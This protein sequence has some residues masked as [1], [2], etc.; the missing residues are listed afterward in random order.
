MGDYQ[1]QH[2][3]AVCSPFS[4]SEH[5]LMI[6]RAV[7]NLSIIATAIPSLGRL[8]VELQPAIHAFAIT[9]Q[10]G[11]RT[12]DNYTLSS[13]AGRYPRDFTPKHNLGT[14][15]SQR[16]TGRQ[17]SSKDD[18]ESTKELRQNMI[19]QTIDFKIY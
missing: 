3:G 10:H 12:G 7:M 17:P 13:F 16:G 14:Q 15:T 18:S 4:P 1:F 9:E 2:M 11:M 6:C 5:D 19:H 8:I